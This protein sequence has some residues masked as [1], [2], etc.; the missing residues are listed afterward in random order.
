M[1]LNAA[2]KKFL[3][4]MVPHHKMA[5]T[6]ANRVITDGQDMRVDALARA[7]RDGQTKEIAQM[8]AWLAEVGEKPNGRMG[9]M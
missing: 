9:G 7:I 5:V 3:K 4:E 2:D 1:T 8:T 6:M